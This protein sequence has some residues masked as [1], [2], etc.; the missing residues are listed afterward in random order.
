MGSTTFLLPKHLPPGAT[1]LLERACFASGYDPGYHLTPEPT[2]AEV[3]GDRLYV[4]RDVSESGYLL[5]P[6]PVE[7]YGSFVVGTTT[8]PER[9]APYAFLLELS[10]GKLSLV[11]NQAAEWQGLGLKTPVDFDRE[12][13]EATR[14]FGKAVL[15]PTPGEADAL[16][17]QVLA[18]AV[19]LADRLVR[20]YTDQMFVLRAKD[21]KPLATRLAART[22]RAPTGP[23]AEDYRQAFTAARV[24]A[25]WTDLEPV[26]TEFDW[27]VT[28][29]AVD[30]AASAGLP[31]T[32]GPVI[33]LGPG[34]LP[35]WAAGWQGDLPTL[36]AFMC[37]Y[38]ETVIGRYQDVVRRWVVCA[39]FNH[40][41]GL[42]LSDDDRL[43]LA[44]RLFDAARQVD[45][46][47]ELVLGVAQP[48]GDYM[49]HDDQT[50]SPFSFADDLLRAGLPVSAVELEIRTGS[51]PRGSLPRDLLDT[52]RLLDVF[53]NNLGIPLEVLLG[54]PAAA[55]P[56]P[57]AEVHGERLDADLWGAG[58]SPEGQAEWGASF[59]E[60]ALCK[61][62]VRA[63]TWDALSDAD[64]HLTPNGGLLD[65]GDRARPLFHRLRAIRTARLS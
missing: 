53:G 58:P 51:S 40:A 52:S 41:D 42:G 47:L 39:G 27:Q 44:A 2:L 33:D 18:R 17:G 3:D 15:A 25:R 59:V 35:A 6:W 49:T 62:H 43:R 63:V 8:L 20:V 54:R 37:D 12:L 14:L 10:R 46:R 34:M 64:P 5:V 9:Q 50:I 1:R 22:S 19:A 26:E 45:P 65:R 29:S 4:S 32:F 38:L 30:F 36:A 21:E 31:L 11:R 57:D 23:T 24:G 7:P 48:W 28:D 16:A 61:P 55:T 60:L 56:D 13:A